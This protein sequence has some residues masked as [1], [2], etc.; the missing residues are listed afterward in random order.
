M[1]S[2]TDIQQSMVPVAVFDTPGEMELLDSSSE[3]LRDDTGLYIIYSDDV[4][5]YVGEY[6]RRGK[7]YHGNNF[8]FIARWGYCSDLKS[9]GGTRS[10]IYHFKAGKINE[11]LTAGRKVRVELITGKQLRSIHPELK[12][13]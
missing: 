2:L 5:M 8:P 11:H 4:P 7:R 12:E 1:Q 6:C 10:R 13:L 9:S 3:L